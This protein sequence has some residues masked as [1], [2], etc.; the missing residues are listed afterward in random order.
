MGGGG[1]ATD[2][3]NDAGETARQVCVAALGVSAQ[4]S[5]VL[6]ARVAPVVG[7]SDSESVIRRRWRLVA[8]RRATA[9]SARL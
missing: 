1:G 8:A 9:G 5:Q 4:H 3:A 6:V 2:S 7:P